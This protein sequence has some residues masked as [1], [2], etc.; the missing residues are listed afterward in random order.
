VTDIAGS[1]GATPVQ[2]ALAWLLAQDE[3]IVPIPGTK[4]VKY[5]EENAGAAALTLTPAVLAEISAAVPGDAVAG[6]RYSPAGMAT[7]G[8]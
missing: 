4:R 8:L 5:L 3:H 6:E 7:V 1:L 2:V